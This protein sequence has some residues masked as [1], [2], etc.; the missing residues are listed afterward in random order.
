MLVNWGVESDRS[1]Y[2]LAPSAG[3]G[4][5][6][7][8]TSIMALIPIVSFIRVCTHT[9][10]GTCRRRQV[11]HG[12]SSFFKKQVLSGSIKLFH[13]DDCWRGGGGGGGVYV[14]LQLYLSFCSSAQHCGGTL[15]R[16][17]AMTTSPSEAAALAD[18]PFETLKVSQPHEYV[19]H[20]QMNRPQKR[21]AMSRK[22]WKWVVFQRLLL[23]HF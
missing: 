14:L 11:V 19:L 6:F 16:L 13:H 22:F 8:L 10:R 4:E 3:N 9:L 1:E 20:V 23:K 17:C 15:Q 2:W 7:F 21:N 5:S 18:Y 12:T